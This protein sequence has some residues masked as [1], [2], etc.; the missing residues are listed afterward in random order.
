MA[1]LKEWVD[2]ENKTNVVNGKSYLTEEWFEGQ[3]ADHVRDGATKV[4]KTDMVD[5]FYLER[6]AKVED[7]MPISAYEAHFDGKGG[8]YVYFKTPTGNFSRPFNK[9]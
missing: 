3:A 6:G 4:I 5:T 1:Y 2:P 7:A 8:S 9:K